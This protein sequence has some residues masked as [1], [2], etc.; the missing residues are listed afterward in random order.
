MPS[1]GPHGE[2]SYAAA[3]AGAAP[4]TLPTAE[5]LLSAARSYL[6]APRLSLLLLFASHADSVQQR[7]FCYTIWQLRLLPS[8][9]E[10]NR[11][12]GAAGDTRQV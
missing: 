8:L 2:G 5:G 11:R 6:P 10:A 9:R 4:L 1:I 3:G 12:Q 7:S